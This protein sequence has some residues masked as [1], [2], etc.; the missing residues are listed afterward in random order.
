[1]NSLPEN[2]SVVITGVVVED[3]VF[4]HEVYGEGFYTFKISAER[5]SENA[6]ILPITVSER[7]LMNQDIQRGKH[8]KIKGQLRSY[9][10][11]TGNRSR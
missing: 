11:Y 1:M 5:L 7:L 8:V 9:N 2:N 3:G 6:D 10:N 4:S